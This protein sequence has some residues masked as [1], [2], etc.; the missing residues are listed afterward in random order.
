MSKCGAYPAGVSGYEREIIGHTRTLDDVACRACGES[1]HFEDK[2]KN[3]N[4]IEIMTM[5]ETTQRAGTQDLID[6]LCGTGFFTAPASSKFHG[7]VEGGLAQHSLNVFD[8]L[9]KFIFD[10]KIDVPRESVVIAALLHDVCK[11]G[12]YLPAD[13]GSDAPYKCN[14]NHPKGHARLSIERVKRFIELTDLEEKMILYHMGVYGLNEFDERRGEY[15]LRDGGMANAWFHHPAVK[16][17]YFADELAAFQEMV[18][19]KN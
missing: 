12:F 5:L 16:L 7:A 17:M 19:E 2:D 3:D 13:A 18:P 15:S 1:D 9:A 8:L 14:K 4:Q 11:V 6:W 10:F